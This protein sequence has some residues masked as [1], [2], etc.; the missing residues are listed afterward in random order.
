MRE[1]TVYFERFGVLD[2]RVCGRDGV[3]GDLQLTRFACGS[4]Q[5]DQA[6]S[7]RIPNDGVDRRVEGV[8]DS[9]LLLLQSD[10]AEAGDSGRKD[11][12]GL[13]ES[14]RS[15]PVSWLDL[16]RSPRRAQYARERTGSW[17]ERSRDS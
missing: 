2:E 1:L 9:F 5:A 13:V 12:F 11:A 14:I 17:T 8:S 3:E 10:S 7:L 6:G 4:T 16:G 15:D